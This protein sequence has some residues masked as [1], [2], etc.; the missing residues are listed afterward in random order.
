MCIAVDEECLRT[1]LDAP[2]AAECLNRKMGTFHI[3]KAVE[4][5]PDV[6]EYD[7]LQG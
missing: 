2:P 5:W 7:D 4:A 3:R 1:L 6:D